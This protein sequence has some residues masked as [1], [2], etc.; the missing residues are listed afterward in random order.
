MIE[1]LV[2][3]VTDRAKTKTFASRRDGKMI[4][5][6][7]NGND[8]IVQ[9]AKR[10]VTGNR[11]WCESPLISQSSRSKANTSPFR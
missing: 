1:A 9:R 10:R 2:V 5:A 6:I 7:E 4:E 8:R 3:I 11:A